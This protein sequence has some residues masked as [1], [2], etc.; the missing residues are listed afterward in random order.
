LTN[1]IA[2]LDESSSSAWQRGLYAFLAE[3]PRRFGS[4]RTVQSYS[5]MLHHFFSPVGGLDLRTMRPKGSFLAGHS[6]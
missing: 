4:M 6:D 3:K 1:F 5:R 2:Y